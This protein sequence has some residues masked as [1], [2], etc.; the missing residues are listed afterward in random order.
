[1]RLHKLKGCVI[2]D[3][4]NYLIKI[5]DNSQ[6]GTNY[7]IPMPVMLEKSYKCTYSA[8]D[9]DSSRNGAG[10]LVRNVL[11]HKVAHCSVTMRSLPN[12]AVGDIM[13]NIQSRYITGKEDEKRVLA[14]VWVPE[15]ND[16]IQSEMYVPDIEFT[17]KKIENGKIFYEQFT[18]EFIGY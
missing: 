15:L 9:M 13:G 2:M 16:Y 3:Y 10:K 18:L 14:E 7:A 12:N 5:I 17:I 6:Y 8:L 1:M 11:P 4:S